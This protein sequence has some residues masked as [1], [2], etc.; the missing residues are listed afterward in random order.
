MTATVEQIIEALR[1]V[2]DP[3][4]HRSIVDLGMVRDVNVSANGVSL[5]VVLTVPGCP[6]RNEIQ[7][8]VTT[9]VAPLAPGGNVAIDFGVMIASGPSAEVRQ[10]PAVVAA[11]L[12]LPLDGED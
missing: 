5:T 3:E 8:R 10:S 6:L 11:Y 4:L 7:N 9:A 12:G 2:E 1:P